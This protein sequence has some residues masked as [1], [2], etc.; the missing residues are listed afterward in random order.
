MIYIEE[1]PSFKGFYLFWAQLILHGVI[2]D[3]FFFYEVKT[4]FYL[5]PYISAVLA[6]Y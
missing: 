4:I 6:L 2:C 3:F 1:F 5:R